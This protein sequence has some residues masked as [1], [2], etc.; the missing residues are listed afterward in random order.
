MVSLIMHSL[1]A[2]Y[3]EV[4]ARVKHHTGKELRRLYIVGGGSQNAL[5]NQLTAEAT[6]LEVCCG[7]TESS[8]LGNFAVQLAAL[9]AGCSPESA[10]F[11]AEIYTWVNRLS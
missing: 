9:E 7:S 8:T 6:G 2:R 11:A 5:L 3:A 1:A 10:A 4:L